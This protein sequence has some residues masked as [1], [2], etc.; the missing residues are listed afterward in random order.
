MVHEN[1]TGNVP[2]APQGLSDRVNSQ[3]LSALLEIF[4]LHLLHPPTASDADKEGGFEK[5]GKKQRGRARREGGVARGRGR[6]RAGEERDASW[7]RHQKRKNVHV[8][9]QREE[10]EQRLDKRAEGIATC[11]SKA[12]RRRRPIESTG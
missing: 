4:R 7:A 11:S 12:M 6:K 2:E 10:V 1:R 9:W 5:G 3:H 8:I